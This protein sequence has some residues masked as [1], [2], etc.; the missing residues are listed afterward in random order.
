MLL[1]QA[2]AELQLRGSFRFCSP[3]LMGLKHGIPFSSRLAAEARR[4]TK[5]IVEKNKD[6]LKIDK[7]RARVKPA[8]QTSCL[9]NWL[10][11]RCDNH[12]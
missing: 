12:S 4:D 8:G 3:E 7:F 2:G 1:F 11:R 9:S 10:S 5:T 6:A